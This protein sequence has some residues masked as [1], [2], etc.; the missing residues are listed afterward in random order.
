MESLNS[1]LPS[2]FNIP[3]AYLKNY[4]QQLMKIWGD[5]TDTLNP[6]DLLRFKLPNTVIDMKTLN[7][8][9]EFTTTAVGTNTQTQA[10]YFPRLSSSIFGSVAVY[11]N[12]VL[13]DNVQNY[14]QLFC[15]LYDA[16]SAATTSS[17][18]YQEANDPSFK[19]IIG[20]TGDITNTIAGNSSSATDDTDIARQFSVRS[21]IGFLGSLNTSIIDV[22]KIGEVVL[23]FTMS[24]ASIIW[25]GIQPAGGAVASPSVQNY[26]IKNYY[27][28]VNRISFGDDL[29]SSY[30][31]NLISTGRYKLTY[32]SYLQARSS[33]VVKS[34]NPT[35]QLSINA[36]TLTK[37]IATAIPSNYATENFIQNGPTNGYTTSTL[38]AAVLSFNELYTKPN[39]YPC[40][41]NNSIYFK[42]DFAGLDTSQI[43]VNGVPQTPFPL[44][45]EQ[46]YSENLNILGSDSDLKA[47]GHP[48]AYSL[49]AWQK[50]YAFHMTS[51]SHRVAGKEDIISGYNSKNSSIQIKWETFWKSDASDS[52]YLTIWAEKF[53]ELSIGADRQIYLIQ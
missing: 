38:S 6:N 37:I 45:V 25:K 7:F 39:S 34:N 50:Y 27:L 43:I 32:L 47:T 21:W 8:I 12:G 51:F 14:N 1:T 23:E 30:L 16:Q 9:F 22:S 10:R 5:K 36:N 26:T 20:S 11:I 46:I 29:Y 53:N 24:P 35:L 19:S 4:S 41:F 2:T 17:I 3:V 44:K 15:L 33:S 13:V 42:K 31:D 48:G 18:R 49:A 52:V 28:T 40:L